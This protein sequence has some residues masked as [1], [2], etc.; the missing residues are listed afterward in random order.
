MVY[1]N[2]IFTHIYV[3]F[4][5]GIYL[6]MNLPSCQGPSEDNRVYPFASAKQVAEDVSG[7]FAEEEKVRQ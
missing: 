3:F 5:I 4:G 7:S 2:E 6:S 1:Y